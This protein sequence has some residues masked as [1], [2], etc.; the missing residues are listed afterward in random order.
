[1][2]LHNVANPTERVA[3]ENTAWSQTLLLLIS[4]ISK[5]G[6]WQKKGNNTLADLSYTSSN[7]YVA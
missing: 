5:F 7:K 6:K 1:M 2:D 3:D 4:C